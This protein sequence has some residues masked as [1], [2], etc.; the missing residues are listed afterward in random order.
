MAEK[1]PWA[2]TRALWLARIERIAA[3]FVEAER[4]RREH[5]TPTAFERRGSATLS[6]LDFTL[7]AKADRID[8]DPNGRFYIY[9]YKT[10][11]PPSAAEQRH[12]DKQLLLEAAIASQGGFERLP[13]AE[14]ASAVFIGLGSGIS[15]VP[16]PLDTD[17][18]EKVWTEFHKLIAAYLSP[19]LGFTSRRAMQKIRHSGDYDHLARFGEWDMTDEPAPEDVGA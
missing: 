5:A 2:A 17:P 12:F 6:D 10:G 1:I 16:A 8:I 11:A 13:A 3:Q 9:D 7:T 14:V 15:E 19:E 18:P 4:A